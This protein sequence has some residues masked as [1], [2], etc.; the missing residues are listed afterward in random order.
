MKNFMSWVYDSYDNLVVKICI[1][2][3]IVFSVFIGGIIT[4]II[5]SFFFTTKWFW[6]VAI[7]LPFLI[8]ILLILNE[9]RKEQK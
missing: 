6:W 7:V 4:V 3:L 2:F 5:M 1:S 8:P 9:Y